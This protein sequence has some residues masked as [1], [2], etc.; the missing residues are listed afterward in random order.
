MTC[1]KK[2]LFKVNSF[3]FSLSCSEGFRFSQKNVWW[4]EAPLKAAFF[5]WSATL[6]KILAM[7][8]S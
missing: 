5:A 8:T 2:G 6:G 7:D 1:I 4:T 3:Y